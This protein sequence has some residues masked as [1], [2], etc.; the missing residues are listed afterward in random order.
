[1]SGQELN[2]LEAV[3][4]KYVPLQ[5]LAEVKRILYGRPA[6]VLELTEAALAGAAEEDYEIAG[7]SIE[8]AAEETR[9]PR[10][11]S[12]LQLDEHLFASDGDDSACLSC[13]TYLYEQYDELAL[14]IFS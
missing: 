4:E 11:V 12:H 2:S 1:M 13:T 5:E 14:C 3:L 10:E 8:A 9:P 7:W 6:G